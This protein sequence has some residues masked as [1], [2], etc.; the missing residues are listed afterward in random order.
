MKI[1]EQLTVQIQ[2]QRPTSP[3]PNEKGLDFAQALLEAKIRNTT[4]TVESTTPV[5]QDKAAEMIQPTP[6][7]AVQAVKIAGLD[8]RL[9][10]SLG[11]LSTYAQ[12]LA[13]P[14]R[15]LKDIAPLADDLEKEVDQLQKLSQ[16]LPPGHSLK[17]LVDQTAVLAA[18]EAAK[19]RRGDYV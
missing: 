1:N 14:A 6:M 9:E 16:G 10:G 18:V 7:A 17:N 4:G 15:T 8:D 3:K 13:D 2:N 19:F 5:T 11:L 12:A